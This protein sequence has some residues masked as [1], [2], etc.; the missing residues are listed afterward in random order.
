M[1]LAYLE[2]E[3]FRGWPQPRRFEFSAD[4]VLV[5]G[6]NGTGKTS[7]FDAILWGLTG[8]IARFGDSRSDIVSKY[9]ESGLAR[10]ELGLVGDHEGV[11]VIR[12]FDGFSPIADP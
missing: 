8:E 12:T 5:T 11:R 4:V 10:V 9:A 6:A 7:L 2:L 3:G 1:R